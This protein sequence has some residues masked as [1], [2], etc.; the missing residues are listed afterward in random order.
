[1]VVSTYDQVLLSIYQFQVHWATHIGIKVKYKTVL[2]MWSFALS[3]P[4]DKATNLRPIS[5]QIYIKLAPYR[6][7]LFQ[8]KGRFIY[9]I[10]KIA[11]S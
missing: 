5:D 9:S 6:D 1:M 7:R 2:K 4:H 3:Y 8:L 11:L 10:A